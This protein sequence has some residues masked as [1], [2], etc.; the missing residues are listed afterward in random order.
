MKTFF[1]GIFIEQD[2]LAA[3]GINYPIKVEYYKKING[4]EVIKQNK[5][6]YGLE[7]VKTEYKDG[8]INIENKEINYVTNN[9]QYLD[10]ILEI[11]K[12]NEV[13][14][15][16]VDDILK[17]FYDIHSTFNSLN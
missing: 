12:R 15:I 5:L 8:E 9:E 3:E 16:S 10:S 6:K 1:G 7:I 4:D 11:F 2:K 17:D 14:P 13:T